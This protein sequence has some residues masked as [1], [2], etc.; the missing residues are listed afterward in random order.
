[1]LSP[2]LFPLS[3]SVHTI[4]FLFGD[5]ACP[6]NPCKQQRNNHKLVP[7]FKL[8]CKLQFYILS[9]SV[10]SLMFQL[11]MSKLC[12]IQECVDVILVARFATRP[13]L[14]VRDCPLVYLCFLILQQTHKNIMNSTYNAIKVCLIQKHKKLRAFVFFF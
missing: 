12:H 11:C 1:M 14:F 2:Q 10:M 7:L 9:T 3:S 5:T 13:F 8:T 6:V 4:A